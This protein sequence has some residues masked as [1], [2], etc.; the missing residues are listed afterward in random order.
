MTTLKHDGPLDIAIGRNRKDTAWR[1]HEMLWSELLMRLSLTHRTAETFASYCS[2]NKSRRD[3]IKDVGGFVGGYIT[4]GRRKHGAILHRSLVSLD[5]DFGNKEIWDD[6]CLLF[7]CAGAIYTTH[8]HSAE[9]PRLRL[10]VPLDRPVACDEYVAISRRIAGTLGI[11]YFDDTT[12][13]PERL[14]YWPSTSSDG[15]FLFDS[16]DGPFLS[17]DEMLGSYKDWTNTA[18]W[19]VSDRVEA[20]VRREATKQGDPCE[21]GGIVGAFCRAYTISEAIEG[22]L[23]DV[24]TACDIPN[25]YTYREGSTSS[26]LVVYEDKYAYSHH[27][28]DPIV[29]KLCNAFDLVR[30][31]LYG[32]QDEEAQEGTPVNRLP[33]YIAMCERATKDAKVRNL[34]GQERLKEAG[35]DFAEQFEEEADMEW[36]S[37][38]DV[39]RRGAYRATSANIRLILENDPQLKG[40]LAHDAFRKT[41]VV[42]KALPWSPLPAPRDLNDTDDAGLRDYLETIYNIT[43]VQKIK[44]AMQITLSKHQFN[45]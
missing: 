20:V 10:I 41:D 34:L 27:S 9:K 21:K 25:R 17:A 18:E 31:H 3:E 33:S 29:G 28:T 13:Q 45:P 22:Y 23:D 38:M 15:E 1:N 30:L 26:G 12:F 16:V 37:E 40:A 36:L 24:Y 8:S 35:A 14:M 43:G 6:F 42:L 2:S 32:L 11:N 19:P 7:N 39:D 44:D 4:G 5:I